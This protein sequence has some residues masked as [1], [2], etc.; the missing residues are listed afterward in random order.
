[1]PHA[2]RDR[3][4]H[5]RQLTT[6]L[7]DALAQHAELRPLWLSI[8]IGMNLTASIPERYAWLWP[9]HDRMRA[10]LS[11]RLEIFV[12]AFRQ[13]VPAVPSWLAS[14]RGKALLREIA[15]RCAA[16]RYRDPCRPVDRRG[17]PPHSAYFAIAEEYC[18]VMTLRGAHQQ[19]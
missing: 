16:G 2:R 19:T 13:R 12:R 11:A 4:A 7:T 6:A 14:S 18:R 1:M 17:R 3:R 10:D 8:V 5:E 9:F 15:E